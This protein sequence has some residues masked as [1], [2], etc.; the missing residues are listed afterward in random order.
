VKARRRGI[1]VLLVNNVL[2]TAGFFMLIPLLSV[3]LTQHLGYTGAI[4]GAVLAVRQLT[5][6]G[7]MVFGGALADRIG[8]RPIIAAG[9]LIRSLGFFG[10]AFAETL[11]AVLASAIVAALGGALFEATGKAALAALAPP[12]ER[13]RLFSLGAV[14]GGIGTTGGPLLGVVLLPI[15]FL[16]VGLAA[17]SFFF[18]AFVIS[19]LLL[20]PLAGAVP[21]TGGFRQTMSS[22]S[23]DRPFLW[24]TALLM[25]YWLLHNQIYISVPLRATQVTGGA[26]IVGLLYAV[27]AGAGLVLQYPLV[28]W[29]SRRFSPV[30]IVGAG[31]ALMGVGLALFGF[32]GTDS[33]AALALMLTA[34]IVFAA[35][36]ALVEPTKDAVTAAMAPPGAMAAYFGISFLALAVGGS[37]GNYAGG[38][39]YDVGSDTGLFAL[40]WLVFLVI[41]VVV[42]AVTLAS[43]SR[44][45]ARMDGQGSSRGTPAGPLRV[46][47]S[48]ASSA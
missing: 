25:G 10:F 9:M 5:Q 20:P 40:P 8:Y 34:V 15:G 48:P 28:R 1:A 4:A 19:L 46:A 47:R 43:A 35:G 27:N 7:L 45:Q 12:E 3:H 31:I 30:I 14:V 26:A 29:A 23:R 17:G 13:A 42:A 36:R 24:F 37:I 32:V 41:G 33:T 22:V 44:L 2:M 39:L 16:Y 11:P 21:G 18:V 6:Q 38:W